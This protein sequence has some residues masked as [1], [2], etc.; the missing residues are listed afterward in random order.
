MKRK[1]LIVLL[2]LALAIVSAFAMIACGETN[3]PDGGNGD[4]GNSTVVT[5]G[6]DT[7]NGGGTGSGGNSGNQ[8]Q[9]DRMGTNADL[10]NIIALYG[11]KCI[12]NASRFFTPDENFI[13][14]FECVILDKEQTVDIVVNQNFY[15]FSP[16]LDGDK[17]VSGIFV[18]LTVKLRSTGETVSEP[19]YYNYG[20]TFSEF[21]STDYTVS[22]PYNNEVWTLKRMGNTPNI[23]F[24]IEVA[25]SDSG[26][27]NDT[28][29]ITN[30]RNLLTN[31]LNTNC[32]ATMLMK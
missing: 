24:E 26:E 31:D 4:N 28:T 5:P 2:A 1:F 18:K 17:I 25:N 10:N 29:I 27:E 12:A 20:L 11:D 23:V 21:Q 13:A 22:N 9:T 8:T 3:K 6:G 15:T 30:P 32:L 16:A 14:E 7:G 19:A